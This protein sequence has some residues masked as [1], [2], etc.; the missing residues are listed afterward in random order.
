[1]LKV[2]SS[3]TAETR[4]AGSGTALMSGLTT[5]AADCEA[6]GVMVRPFAGVGARVTIGE[7]EA[8]DRVIELARSF[9]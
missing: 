7:T 9:G 6:V 1:M 5:F 4:V 8:N 2:G 3:R